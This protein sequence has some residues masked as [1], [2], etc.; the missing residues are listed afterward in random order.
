MNTKFQEKI[1]TNYNLIQSFKLDQSNY[2]DM[3]DVTENSMPF[4][5]QYWDQQQQLDLGSMKRNGPGFQTNLA[6]LINVAEN[7]EEQKD[8]LQ[9]DLL[10]LTDA[11][12]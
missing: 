12:K 1:K 10:Q 4:I 6:D 11:G 5:E 7:L 3:R 2:Y 9:Q 8:T